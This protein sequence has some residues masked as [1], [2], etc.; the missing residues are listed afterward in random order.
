LP[1]YL[2]PL[3]SL[4]EKGTVTAYAAARLVDDELY[5]E[6]RAYIAH[7]VPTRRAEFGTARVLARRAM[8]ELGIDPCPLV[9][10]AD[11]SP[12]WPADVIGSI[13]HTQGHCFVAVARSARVR[14][15]GLDAEQDAGL[16][17]NLE[18]MICT[19]GERRWLKALPDDRRDR[20]GMVLFSAKEAFYKCQYPT[21][22]TFLDFQEVE[23]QIDAAMSTF[24]VRRVGGN[25]SS[26]RWVEQVRGRLRL[27]GGLIMAAAIA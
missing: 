18:A 19:E 15:L 17:R 22:R 21:T 11:R 8:S 13:S 4:F 3:Q 25:D 26:R 1:D 14:A 20:A 27:A 9:P 23:I 5:P 7:A 24:S 16:G 6:E 10:H 2:R 12:R